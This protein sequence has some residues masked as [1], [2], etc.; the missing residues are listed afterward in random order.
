MDSSAIVVNGSDLEALSI[1]VLHNRGSV[2][3]CASRSMDSSSSSCVSRSIDS[4][5]STSEGAL[6]SMI[7][8]NPEALSSKALS[9]KALLSKALLSKD[10]SDPTMEEG[11]VPVSDDKAL[12]YLRVYPNWD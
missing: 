9:S 4:S 12:L 5:V 7:G 1:S 2:C 3:I 8:S 11:T 10:S 6:S